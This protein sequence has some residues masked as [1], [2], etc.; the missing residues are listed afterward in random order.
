MNRPIADIQFTLHG[1][2]PAGEVSVRLRRF[3]ERWVAESA[4]RGVGTGVGLSARAAL[5]AA[6]EP[7]GP[8]AARAMLA[9]VALLGPSLRV[10]DA[11]RWGH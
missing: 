9:D 2:A 5:S 11:E 10:L 6:V 1:P 3:G 8:V 4:G 7:F